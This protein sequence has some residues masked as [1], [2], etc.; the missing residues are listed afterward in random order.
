MHSTMFSQSLIM[1]NNDIR[2]G[3]GGGLSIMN[4]DVETDHKYLTQSY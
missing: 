4:D 3:G 1:N 2:G